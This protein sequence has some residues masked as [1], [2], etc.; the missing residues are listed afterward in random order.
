MASNAVIVFLKVPEKG[1]VKTR[2]SECLS[3]TFVLALYKG[4]VSDI[5]ETIE[6]AGDKF[7]YFWPPGGKKRLI[8]FLGNRYVF[9]PQQGQDLGERMAN[10]FVDTFKKGY[11]QAILIGTDIPELGKEVIAQ[12]CEILESEDAV[13][14]PSDDGGYYLIGFRNTTFSK[15]IFTQI[16]WS[17]KAVLDQTLRAMN[18]RSIDCKQLLKLSDIDTHEDLTALADRVKKGGKIGTRTLE[19]LSS[20]EA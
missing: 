8:N 14:G 18:Q 10:A 7:L 17:T 4:F 5:L 13:I 19:I 2:L 6:T 3:Q 20:Y 12:A 16:D 9:F 15:M 1:Q 11:T